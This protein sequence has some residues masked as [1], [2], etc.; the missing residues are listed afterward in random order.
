[1]ETAHELI[2]KGMEIRAQQT[3]G[4]ALDSLKK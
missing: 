3:L 4:A 1:M 2:G